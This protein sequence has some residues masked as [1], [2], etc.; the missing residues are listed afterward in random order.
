VFLRPWLWKQK[1]KQKSKEEVRR[2]SL[3]SELD[4]KPAVPYSRGVI[5]TLYFLRGTA[6][7]RSIH[8][9][10]YVRAVQNL[11]LGADLVVV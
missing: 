8:S 1:Q 4:S 5:P 6:I 7:Y 10:A 11:W 2:R 3:S 9:Y